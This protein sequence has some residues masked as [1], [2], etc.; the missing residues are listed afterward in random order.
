MDEPKTDNEQ[1]T[2]PASDIE[3]P[4]QIKAQLKP[5]DHPEPENLPEHVIEQPLP[6]TEQLIL[7]PKSRAQAPIITAIIV[8]LAAM[9]ATTYLLVKNKQSVLTSN[10]SRPSQS[11][12]VTNL[13]TLT[14][15]A[16]YS[17]TPWPRSASSKSRSSFSMS[18]KSIF[19]S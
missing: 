10:S 19:F 13:P 18:V 7:P 9:A 14:G 11:V 16:S 6:Q 1:K 4:E 8:L 17:D 5:Q 2:Q 12:N 15:Q 3:P